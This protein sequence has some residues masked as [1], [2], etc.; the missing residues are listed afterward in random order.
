MKTQPT[1]TSKKGDLRRLRD[2]R[3]LPRHSSESVLRLLEIENM[4]SDTFVNANS[5]EWLHIKH[6][7]L[8][9]ATPIEAAK[10][11]YGY[12]RV[13]DLLIATKYGGAL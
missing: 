13:K 11:S 12:Q 10:T 9:G 6:P 1:Q 3:L 2:G 8:D 4:V 7:M 5:C